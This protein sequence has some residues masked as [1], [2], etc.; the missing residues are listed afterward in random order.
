MNRC[1]DHEKVTGDLTGI[2]V[3]GTGIPGFARL[4]TLAFSLQHLALF[5]H[6]CDC[7]GPVYV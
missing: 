1:F 3:G 5:L 7:A 4:R 2:F 6:V